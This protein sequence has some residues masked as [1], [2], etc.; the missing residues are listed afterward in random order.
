MSHESQ[1]KPTRPTK[2]DDGSF[3]GDFGTTSESFPLIAHRSGQ[4]AKEIKGR[5]YYYGKWANWREAIAKYTAQ[6]TPIEPIED[7]PEPSPRESSR[8]TV[9]RPQK[10]IDGSYRVGSEFTPSQF[11]LFPHGSGQWAKKING[12]M[13]YFGVWDQWQAALKSFERVER[14]RLATSRPESCVRNMVDLFLDAQELRAERG[15]VSRR[16]YED[17]KFTL[18][19][20]AKSLGEGSDLAALTPEDWERWREEISVCKKGQRIGEQKRA[21]SVS[22]DVVR[23]QAMLNWLRE[24]HDVRFN[25]GSAMEKMSAAMKRKQKATMPSGCWDPAE[26]RAV[27]EHCDKVNDRLLKAS[28]LLAINCGFLSS[29]IGMIPL[30][31]A[32]GKFAGMGLDGNF[33]TLPRSKNFKPRKFYLWEETLNAMNA[34][35]AIRPASTIFYSHT[36]AEA[37]YERWFLSP[38]GKVM[39][40]SPT[41]AIGQKM[42]RA[43]SNIGLRKG[44]DGNKILFFKG[45]RTT[46]SVVLQRTQVRDV[47]KS[48]MGHHNDVLAEHYSGHTADEILKKASEEL[49]VWYHSGTEQDQEQDDQQAEIIAFRGQF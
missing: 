5:M 28:T 20:L 31:I 14:E 34:Y 44:L 43:L 11:P 33:L 15:T 32:K 7:K 16:Q 8:A 30:A 46:F 27:V 1:S 29:D 36:Q 49:R 10:N 18:N 35:L 12:A 23:V 40:D 17:Y 26:I 42:N 48:M 21:Q 6:L 4:W 38:T 19:A 25:T 47:V 45:L 9:D 39:S 2:Q 24:K 13:R 41:C 22:N 3:V 37:R